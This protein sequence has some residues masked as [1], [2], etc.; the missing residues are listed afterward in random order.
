MNRITA[1][2]LNAAFEAFRRANA[3]AGITRT[4]ERFASRDGIVF[5]ASHLRLQY[6]S[7]T[8]SYAFRVFYVEPQGGGHYSLLSISD[9]LGMTKR[10]AYNTLMA[11]TS[12]INAV[13]DAQT[14][15]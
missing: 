4:A 3:R 6:G 7:K 11:L 5:D 15:Q 1:K 14:G 9:Y 13:L 2:R 8:Y 12:G 10:E